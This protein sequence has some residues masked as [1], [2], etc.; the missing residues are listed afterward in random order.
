MFR[1]L[2]V[3]RQSG[4]VATYSDH[5]VRGLEM[6]G[7]DVVLDDMSSDIPDE[8][9]FW[10]DRKV[11]QSL[12]RAAQGFDLVHAWGYRAAWACGEAFYIRFPWVYTAYDFPRTR[13]GLLVDR[14]NHAKAGI[15]TSR[16]CLEELQAV[17][18]LNL[19]V[20]APAL[21]DHMVEHDREEAKSRLGLQGQTVAVCVA[22]PRPD[23]GAQEFAEAAKMVEG[24]SS[25]LV[26]QYVPEPNP[27]L[28]HFAESDVPWALAAADLVVV[29]GLRQSF[30]M[31]A[32]EAMSMGSPVA[33]RT[34]PGIEEMGVAGIHFH[35]FADIDELRAL[36]HALG[37]DPVAFR[38]T[39]EPARMRAH[40]WYG[41][42]ECA[43]RHLDL[44]RAALGLA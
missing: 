39:V 37:Q 44:Y 10:I 4:G 30:S 5:L 29:P 27:R 6:L 41:M 21:S 7:V 14:L 2:M 12:K 36:L 9:G 28:L 17:D 40:D 24:V 23:R 3:R 15:V 11:S 1:V 18:T 16:A 35:G 32:L 43:R 38:S 31:V 8:T 13:S 25:V 26:S 34:A 20:V 33:I 22:G 42:E 19:S